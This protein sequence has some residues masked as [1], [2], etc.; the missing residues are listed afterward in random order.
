M[1]LHSEI[2][3]LKFDTWSYSFALI[4]CNFNSLNETTYIYCIFINLELCILKRT[5]LMK[6]TAFVIE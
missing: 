1:I 4:I 5:Y 6:R 2:L 3:Q